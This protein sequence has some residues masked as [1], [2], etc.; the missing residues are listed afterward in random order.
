MQGYRRSAGRKRWLRIASTLL[1]VAGIALLL[2]AAVRC[3]AAQWEQLRLQARLA[4]ATPTPAAR[5]EP[6]ATP[7]PVAIRQST[8][9]PPPTATPQPSATPTPDVQAA[10]P[11]TQPPTATP[12]AVVTPDPPTATPS[13]SPALSAEV[14]AT[15]LNVRA[16]PGTSFRRLG[17]LQ[18]DQ[19]VT[20]LARNPEGTWLQVCCVDGQQGWVSAEYVKLSQPI[21]T[22]AEAVA[23]PSAPPAE[24]VRIVIPDLGIDAPVEEVGWQV[25]EVG[26]EMRSTWEL[27]SFAAGHHS[28]SAL[29]GQS[30]N[31]VIS[32]HHN[33][34]G[35][36][37]KNISLAWDEDAAELQEDGITRRS[38]VLDGR[39]VTIYDAAGRAFQ[40]VIE[41]MY[42]MPDRDVSEAQRRENARFIAPT[43]EPILT[44]VTC[45]P[46]TNNT[47]RIV[48]VARLAEDQG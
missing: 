44:L 9:P 12:T 37:F 34:E 10:P 47:H 36:V 21:G 5:R 22:I 13:P 8:A 48:V 33:I 31:V 14:T 17:S 2:V 3:G 32:G 29:P 6:A 27:A 18:R 40:Y 42:N 45:W 16:G 30:G 7:T 1:I 23:L 11:P 15:T 41:G 28:N 35:K 26:G 39:T 19:R 46:Y 24:P 43:S 25:E 38:T 20:V 4:Q